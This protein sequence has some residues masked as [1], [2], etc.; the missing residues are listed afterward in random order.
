MSANVQSNTQIK[1][2]SVQGHSS[3]AQVLAM[4]I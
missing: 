4:K 2:V 1:K 3:N